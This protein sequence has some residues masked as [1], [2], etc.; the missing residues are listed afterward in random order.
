MNMQPMD[1]QAL[2]EVDAEA[3][4]YKFVPLVHGTKQPS[5]GAWPD[6][7]NLLSGCALPTP[8]ERFAGGLTKAWRS[9]TGWL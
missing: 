9:S 3:E 8:G 1:M 4:G 2:N 7:A 6:R 5:M